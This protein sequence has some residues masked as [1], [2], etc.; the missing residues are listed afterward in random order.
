MTERTRAIVITGPFED[1]ELEMLAK[2]MRGIERLRPDQTFTMVI[3]D[4]EA[5]GFE[6]AFKLMA[7]IFPHKEPSN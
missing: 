7:S 1:W 6:S 4:A 3:D 2:V 5:Q